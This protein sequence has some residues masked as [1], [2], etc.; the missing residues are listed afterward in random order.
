M[1]DDKKNHHARLGIGFGT[2]ITTMEQ[3]RKA[4]RERSSDDW[5]T[6]GIVPEFDNFDAP[7]EDGFFRARNGLK[8]NPAKIFA[9]LEEENQPA[10]RQ[11]IALPEEDAAPVPRQKPKLDA[12]EAP[13]FP[14]R[15]PEVI[16]PTPKGNEILDFI[17]EIESSDNYNV[18]FG[19]QKKPLTKMTLK[20]VFELPKDPSNKSRHEGVLNNKALTDFETLKDVL[21]KK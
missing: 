17:G 18:I 20:Q 19:G 12:I 14:K 3:L 11:E 1:F 9:K 5:R 4:E 21:E 2:G 15:K 13:P 7:D 16:S 8:F 10:Q 6:P